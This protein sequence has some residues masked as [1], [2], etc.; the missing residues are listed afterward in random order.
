M[1]DLDAAVRRVLSKFDPKAVL[2]MATCS[3][4]Q[5]ESGILT[6][7]L[8]NNDS[9]RESKWTGKVVVVAEVK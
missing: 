4:V 5:Q 8:P 6:L 1:A 7:A 2:Q 3:V 9:A